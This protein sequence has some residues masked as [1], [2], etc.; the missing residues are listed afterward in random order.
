MIKRRTDKEVETQIINLENEIDLL[1]DT[2]QVIYLRQEEILKRRSM[3][4]ALQ[5]TIRTDKE[6]LNN[7]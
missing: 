5:W 7:L 4:K 6:T 3:I 2:S 1:S